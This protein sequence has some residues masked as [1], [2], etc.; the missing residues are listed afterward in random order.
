MS[1][2][3]ASVVFGYGLLMLLSLA[4]LGMALVLDV[5]TGAGLGEQFR[6]SFPLFI[7]ASVFAFITLLLLLLRV[8]QLCVSRVPTSDSLPNLCSCPFPARGRRLDFALLLSVSA[9]VICLAIGL[10]IAH[11]EYSSSCG[12]LPPPNQQSM[13]YNYYCHGAWEIVFRWSV[14][15]LVLQSVS[16]ALLTCLSCPCCLAVSVDHEFGS[17]RDSESRIAAAVATRLFE[18]TTRRPGYLRVLP[19]EAEGEGEHESLR[20]LEGI[21]VSAADIAKGAALPEL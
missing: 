9:A 12:Q 20:H 10:A 13:P 1:C 7:A 15:V 4:L 14:A 19:G 5:A 16:L 17:R 3:N 6:S 11:S 18:M 2:P 21:A 8:S